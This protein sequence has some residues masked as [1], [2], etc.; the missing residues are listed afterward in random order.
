MGLVTDYEEKIINISYLG[1]VDVST[2]AGKHT[3]LSRWIG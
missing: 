2:D 1:T 3:C